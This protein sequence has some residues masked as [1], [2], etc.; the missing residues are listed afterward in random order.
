MDARK[1]ISDELGLTSND[2][3]KL[4][5]TDQDLEKVT[6]GVGSPLD[7][8]NQKD[9]TIIRRPDGTSTTIIT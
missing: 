8:M 1:T 5:L 4:S 2:L 9:I 3:Q 7:E 6:G